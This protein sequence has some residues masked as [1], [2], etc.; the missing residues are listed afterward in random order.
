MAT[1]ER[2]G[3]HR[4]ERSTIGAEQARKEFGALMD[5]AWDGEHFVITRH[6]RERCVIVGWR[7]YQ[8]AFGGR[9][10]ERTGRNE[11]ADL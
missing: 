3:K 2:K 7:E 4:P 5:R 8:M 9:L 10:V 6:D 11:Q 1:T